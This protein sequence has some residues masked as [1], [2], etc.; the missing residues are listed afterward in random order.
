[1]LASNWPSDSPMI[2]RLAAVGYYGKYA[3]ASW[4]G[5]VPQGMNGAELLRLAKESEPEY[6][7]ICRGDPAEEVKKRGA[8]L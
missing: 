6:R 1:M 7:K 2:R 8:D 4:G 5:L 3:K